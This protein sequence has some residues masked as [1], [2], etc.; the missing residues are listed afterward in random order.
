VLPHGLPRLRVDIRGE[1]GLAENAQFVG[2]ELPDKMA[3]RRD[4][5]G[6]DDGFAILRADRPVQHGG[7]VAR[8]GKRKVTSSASC[9]PSLVRTVTVSCICCSRTPYVVPR[10]DRRMPSP[11]TMP[12]LRAAAEVRWGA[13]T[14]KLASRDEVA[15]E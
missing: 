15:G 6:P 8:G 7:S 2:L 14:E 10:P 12:H 13:N 3:H 9:N 5:I 4:D 1:A 11:R